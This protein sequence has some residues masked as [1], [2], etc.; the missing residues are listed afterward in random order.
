M[1]ST[2]LRLAVALLTFGLGVSVTT[3][4]IA[5]RTPEIKS[6][7][8][9]SVR[10]KECRTRHAYMMA[11]LPAV[12]EPLPPSWDEPLP[13]PPPLPLLPPPAPISGG[14]LD[15]K[16]ISKPQPAYPAIE[17]AARVSGTVNVQVI[18]DES[19][20]VSSAKAVS[21]YPLLQRAAVEAAYR[22]RFAPTRLSG[23]PV[24]VSGVL[25]YN[26]VLP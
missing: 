15:G 8:S 14:I 11:P 17:G 12:E 5:Y 1:P 6:V 2:L 4:W 16:A 9:E 20:N 24:K 10:K 18:V 3:L 7:K 13:P 22:A 19:G 26:F 25:S 21:G 23:Q